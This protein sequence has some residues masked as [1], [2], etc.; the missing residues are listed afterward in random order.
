MAENK[1]FKYLVRVANTD[2]DGK[3]SI[4]YALTKIKGVSIMYANAVCKLS[5]LDVH[6]KAGVLSDEEIATLNEQVKDISKLPTWLLNRRN[7][8]TTGTDMH[9]LDADLVFTKDNDLKRLKM[10]KSYRGL[11]HQA[12]LT[13]R[14]QR[15]KSNFRRTKTTRSKSKK[16]GK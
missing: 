4:L 2:L 5:K 15:T 8:Y 10:I 16:R 6:K 7:D 9:L 3:K 1:D 13:V 12:G 14:G 11:R